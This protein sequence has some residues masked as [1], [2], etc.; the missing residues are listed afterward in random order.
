MS[1]TFKLAPNYPDLWR[2]KHFFPAV[3][4]GLAIALVGIGDIENY[5]KYDWASVGFSG[6]DPL[7]LH[8]HAVG[9]YCIYDIDS[10]AVAQAQEMGI[11]SEVLDLCKS[12]LASQYD[13]IFAADVIEHT[14][15]PIK[16][17]ENVANSLTPNGIGI[18]TTPNPDFWRNAIPFGLKEE[19]THLVSIS[20]RH[21]INMAR[22]LQLDIIDLEDFPTAS[23]F[24]DDYSGVKNT[25][26]SVLG[27]IL[28]YNSLLFTFRRQHG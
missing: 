22:C 26:H 25:Y 12:P 2:S 28:S 18:I 8:N 7:Y 23:P 4:S 1:I 16:F 10:H 14:E 6:F 15:A 21:F 17:L 20:K 11:A 13:F 19:K 9:S 3:K 5:H 24:L 27:K